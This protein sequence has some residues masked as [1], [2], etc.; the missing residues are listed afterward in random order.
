MTVANK[1]TVSTITI[2]KKFVS[3][4]EL[5]P[6]N[7]SQYNT[8]FGASCSDQHTCNRFLSMSVSL[9]KKQSQPS[10]HINRKIS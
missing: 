9:K 8:L 4:T 2:I 10:Y 1:R 7:T 6:N 3:K 5:L